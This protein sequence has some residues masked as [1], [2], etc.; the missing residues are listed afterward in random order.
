V[1][2]GRTRQIKTVPS[3]VDHGRNVPSVLDYRIMSPTP[4]PDYL[5]E[6]R[7]RVDAVQQRWNELRR[8]L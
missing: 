6:L 5:V 1:R 8:Y 7:N 3:T 2:S 4:L